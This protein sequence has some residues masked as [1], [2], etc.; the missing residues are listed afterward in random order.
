MCNARKTCTLEACGPTVCS[1]FSLQISNNMGFPLVATLIL[2]FGLLWL[3]M[4]LI[5]SALRYRSRG[6]NSGAVEENLPDDFGPRLTSRRLRYVRWAFAL[7]VLATLGF[8]AY[9][10]LFSTGPLGENLTFAGLKDRRD[11][12][13]RREME[14]TLRGWIYDRHHDP[15]RALAKYRYLNGDIIRDYPLG[16]SAAHIVGYGTLSRGDALLERAVTAPHKVETETN[17]W[18]TIARFS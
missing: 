9:W 18:Q 5:I 12:R 14:S 3:L 11:Q 7:I 4:S 15:R 13:N 8:H 10:G 17:W 2:L 1:V 16:P 6:A